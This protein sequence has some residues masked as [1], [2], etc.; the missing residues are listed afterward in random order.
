M[1]VLA[2]VLAAFI[3]FYWFKR[4]KNGARLLPP[5]PRGLPLLGSLPFLANDLH[6]WFAELAHIYGPVMSLRLGAKLCVV[7]SSPE[8]VKEALNDREA[9]FANHD[10]P[11]VA[12][13]SSYGGKDMF[14]A[15]YGPHWRMLRKVTVRELLSPTTIEGLSVLRRGEIRR[16]MEEIGE[17]AG[18][19][20][21][22]RELVSATAM[23]VTTEM[24]W[25]GSPAQN[26]EEKEAA[27]REFR[28]VTEELVRLLGVPNISDF[29]PAIAWLDLQGLVRWMRRLSLW[30]E[31]IF[32]FIIEERLMTMEAR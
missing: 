15:P 12:L 24:L 11:A 23:N 26:G 17:K 31:R 4:T 1:A 5:G 32:N 2:A 7:L 9:I 8:A 13:V 20:V 10:I 25:G 30:V 21:N 14:W 22:V 19:P 29:F 28:K 3:V 16:T 27:G 6:V 18:Q